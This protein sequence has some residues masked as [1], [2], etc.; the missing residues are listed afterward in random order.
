M[1]AENNVVDF[2]EYKLIRQ[3]DRASSS[4]EADVSYAL[5][6]MYRDGR[7]N[8]VIRDGE[9][10]FESKEIFEDDGPVHIP[11]DPWEW[12]DEQD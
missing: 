8:V 4:I 1:L 12:V 9:L 2:L 5:L 11:V 10:L 6:E 3:L 7:V